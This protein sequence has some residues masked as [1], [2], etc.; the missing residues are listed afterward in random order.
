MNAPRP[1]LVTSLCR[2]LLRATSFLLPPLE[3]SD[4]LAE[5][6]AELHYVLG[7]C[8][9]HRACLAFSLGAVCDAF[10]IRRNSLGAAPWLESPRRCLAV[11]A[12]FAA[13]SA[14]LALLL[15]AVRQQIFPPS[16]QGP[17]DVVIV[18]PAPSLV[19]SGMQVSA[20]Q[21]LA[22]SAHAHP[23]LAQIGFYLPTIADAQIDT[24]TRKW[25]IGRATESFP[26]LLGIHV[27]EALRATC[28]RYGAR[29]IVLSRAAWI[30]DFAADPNIIGRV[31]NLSGR[32]AVVVAI[33][34]EAASD[35][36][37]Q[38]DAWS[39]ET[40]QGMRTL[41]SRSFNYGY[42]LAHLAPGGT[43]PLSMAR[44]DLTSDDG[45]QARLFVIRLSSLAAYDRRIPYVDFLMALFMTALMLPAILAISV[46]SGL[47]TERLSFRMRTRG[48]LFLGAKIVL[49]LPLLYCGPLVVAQAAATNS[50]NSGYALQIIA[51][52]GSALLAAFWVVDDQRKRCPDCLRILTSPARVGER[53]RSFLSF[54]GME[55]VCAEGHGLLHV[56]DFPTSWFSSQRWLRLDPSWHDLFLHGR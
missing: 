21:Y 30:R 22:W 49:L 52:I 14:A 55:F 20:T 3:R 9:P 47:I 7:R 17:D 26:S 11:L 31:L 48:W 12:T 23:A 2:L 46:R 28:S 53:S 40:T 4:W 54:S 37:L 32:K 45:L 35:L 18:S 33:A 38:M 8:I 44:V 10:W 15:P 43:M 42:M 36:P 51:T 19:G 25:Y 5:W 29:A 6:R 1:A 16:Y 27:S 50:C 56:P 13:G 41:A 24:G 34:P 39:L